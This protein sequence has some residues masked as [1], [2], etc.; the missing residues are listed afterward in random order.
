M[1]NFSGGCLLGSGEFSHQFIP[2]E[3]EFEEVLLEPGDSFV[4]EVMVVD[5]FEGFEHILP[6]FWGG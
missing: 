1:G 2:F 6:L 5:I 3:S 4:F